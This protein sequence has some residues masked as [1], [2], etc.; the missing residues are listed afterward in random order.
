MR[1]GELKAPPDGGAVRAAVLD[2]AVSWP[3]S[4]GDKR[5]ADL[6][7]I[8][9]AASASAEHGQAI[10]NRVVD[11]AGAVFKQLRGNQI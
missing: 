11:G 3:W 4:S 10:V 8:G 6:G 7:V 5:I 9:D 1:F 2:P